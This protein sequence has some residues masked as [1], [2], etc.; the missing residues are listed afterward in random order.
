MPPAEVTTLLLALGALLTAA[1]LLGE[2]AR[3]LGQA[4]VL[5]EIVAGIL[6]G[7]TV[8][9][10]IAPAGADVVFPWLAAGSH[11]AV[12]IALSGF[13]TIAVVLF[14]LVAGLEVHLSTVAK[15]GRVA[16]A[17]SIAGVVVPFL[18]GA[19]AA[20]QL[21]G[22]LGRPEHAS[23]GAF[24]LFIATAMAISAL[25]VIAKTLMD[26]DLYRTDVGMVV[27]GAAIVQDV[28]GWLFFAVVL[29]LMG[30]GGDEGGPL[31]T[32]LL[33]L[34]F[35]TA[36]VTVG[37]WLINRALP[38]V[39]AH[40]SWPGGVLGLIMALTFFGAA[41]SEWSG[42]HA[43]FGAFMVGV[44]LGDSPH[45]Q[46]R[47][48]RV[49]EQFVSYAFAPIFFASIG[50]KADF[51]ALFDWRLTSF[52]L[53]I[54][55]IGKVLGCGLGA[56]AAGMPR[57]EAWA[58]GFAMNARGAMEIILGALALDYAV[59]DHRMFVALVVM[60]LATSLMSGPVM[61]RILARPK[62]RRVA[63]HLSPRTFVGRL[64]ATDSAGAVT[65]LSRLV[66]PA[67]GLDAAAIAA[68]VN[69]R[70]EMMSTCI[71]ESLAVPHARLDGLKAPAVAV[72]L[73]SG[74]GVR[75]GDDAHAT[76]IFLVLT[77]RED[78][79]AQLEL[80][81][82]IARTLRHEETRQRAGTA[83]GFTEFIGALRTA[84]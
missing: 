50:L 21:P 3:K 33:V 32:V 19:G 39:H 22:F 51:I 9:G 53:A 80:L 42:I 13:T 54:A 74:E 60:A 18:L 11:P 26:L 56:R 38:W 4:A 31:R 57:R 10:H 82:D 49:V 77:P 6:L 52:I 48:R 30:H 71:G 8:L 29:G 55:C 79:G 72:G 58:V 67:A 37:R 40:A 65:E 66:A 1:R 62:P 16:L 63:D 43:I 83:A 2:L 59:I 69:E 81:A 5:G 12:M 61:Q 27:M 36:M 20:W 47:T 76:I 70:E 64:A 15:Q 78:D 7:P 44:A 14:L 41:Y 46:E 73:S 25:P 17:V 23:E 34:V 84:H 24:T 68:A 45:L 28:V 75:F 35:A